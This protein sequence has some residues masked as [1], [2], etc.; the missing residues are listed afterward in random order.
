M[1]EANA[2]LDAFPVLHESISAIRHQPE[3][4][5]LKT[6]GS[7]LVLSSPMTTDEGGHML[8]SLPVRQALFRSRAGR[9]KRDFQN[10]SCALLVP[11]TIAVLKGVSQCIRC[12]RNSQ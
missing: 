5:N 1:R 10:D 4:M 3:G 8:A 12:G 6:A 7:G 2:G 9:D 11:Q